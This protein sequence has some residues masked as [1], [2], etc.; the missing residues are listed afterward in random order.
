MSAGL[1]PTSPDLDRADSLADRLGSLAT[2]AAWRR[3]GDW[4]LVVPSTAGSAT[5]RRY[6]KAVLVAE[7]R[8]A[9]AGIDDPGALRWRILEALPAPGS[10]AEARCLRPITVPILGDLA[11]PADGSL[12]CSLRV[13]LDLAVFEGHFPAIPIVPAVVQVGWAVHLLQ[14]HLWPRTH[15]VGITL[16][17]FRRLMRPGMAL[18]LTIELAGERARFDYCSRGA[19]V[20]AGRLLLEVAHG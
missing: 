13:P 14:A 5:L 4:V 1:A 18:T 12:C 8:G 7:W 16:A 20:S 17:K 2:V 10:E 19:P 6:G 11:F 3:V 15:V 9:L